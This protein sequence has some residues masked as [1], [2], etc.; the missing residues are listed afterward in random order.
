MNI[1]VQMKM[2]YSR[3]L[4]VFLVEFRAKERELTFS[5]RFFFSS[6]KTCKVSLKL[7]FCH[8]TSGIA[9]M[10]QGV[11]GHDQF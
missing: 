7:D 11:Q 1:Y 6:F 2:E 10:L 5:P 4:T 9:V 8:F 3:S